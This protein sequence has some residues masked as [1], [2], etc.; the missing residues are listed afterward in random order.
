LRSRLVN[1]P[2][3]DRGTSVDQALRKR[4]LR[5]CRCLRTTRTFRAGAM[6]PS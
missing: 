3:P 2:A 4:P 6:A 5:T 1:T